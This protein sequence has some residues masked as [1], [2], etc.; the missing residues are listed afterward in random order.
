MGF[1]PQSFAGLASQ[2]AD[3][4]KIAP[5][6]ASVMM[7]AKQLLLPRFRAAMASLTD[8][9]SPND[10]VLPLIWTRNGGETGPPVLDR[11]LRYSAYR[12]Q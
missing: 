6:N 5:D 9:G 2:K 8:S 3:H 12:L 7:G 4:G 10:V 1:R 11:T